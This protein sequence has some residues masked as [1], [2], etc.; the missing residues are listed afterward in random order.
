MSDMIVSNSST[1]ATNL[2]THL[3]CTRLP[4]W[5]TSHNRLREASQ[6]QS[7]AQKSVLAH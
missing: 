3:F 7:I 4:N 6:Y 5:A 2:F 1:C